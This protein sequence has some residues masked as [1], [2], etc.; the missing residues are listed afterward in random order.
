MK[1]NSLLLCTVLICFNLVAQEIELFG[2]QTAIYPQK[3]VTDSEEKGKI[4]SKE[5]ITHLTIP[6][7]FNNYETILT[8]T[9]LYGHLITETELTLD[10]TLHKN[11]SNYHTIVY[12]LNLNQKLND[13]WRLNVGIS[14]SLA[15]NFNEGLT[16]DDVLFQANTMLI[17]LKNRNFNYGFGLSYSTRFG[18][19]LI[20]PILALNFKTP[21][22]SINIILPNKIALV[23]N[24]KNKNL[25]YGVKAA[26][27]GALF[28][29]QNENEEFNAVIDEAGYSRLNIGPLVE[30]R[31]KGELYLRASGGFTV[32]RRLDFIGKDEKIID[33]TPDNGP[34][35]NFGISYFPQRKIKAKKNLEEGKH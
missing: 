2:L 8:H 26:L 31:L 11:T 35:F 28:N 27:N 15:S 23:Y 5:I 17:R 14:P 21:L 32:A 9:V 34:F 4:G 18:R 7:I 20:I 3:E 33:R 10:T 12:R 19:K 22:R 13:K 1:K 6:Q 25:F 30:I 29:V 16:E 24:T